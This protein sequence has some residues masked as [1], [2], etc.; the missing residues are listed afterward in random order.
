MR[1]QF[2]THPAFQASFTFSFLIGVFFIFLFIGGTSILSLYLLSND[3]LISE[4]Q[5]FI[6][7]GNA[8]EFA[9]YL[10]Y[11]TVLTL[12]VLGWVGFYLSYKFVGPLYRLE[13]WLADRLEKQDSDPIQLRPGDEME[14][15]SDILNRLIQK[16]FSSKGDL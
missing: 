1:R 14:S 16:K 3:P 9:V 5:K 6:L 8:K 12:L 2:V 4:T 7:R 13:S 10:G 11:L 15:L